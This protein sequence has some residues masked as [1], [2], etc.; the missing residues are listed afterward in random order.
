ML[1]LSPPGTGIGRFE[2]T[3]YE[4]LRIAQLKYDDIF[5]VKQK[6]TSGIENEIN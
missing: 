3:G 1:E 6:D 5:K 2:R 4:D